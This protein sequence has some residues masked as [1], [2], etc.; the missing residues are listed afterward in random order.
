MFLLRLTNIMRQ[1]ILPRR[2]NEA[3]P[4]FLLL[5]V[6]R[7]MITN[8]ITNARHSKGIQPTVTIVRYRSHYFIWKYL[9]CPVRSLD[10]PYNT[11][12]A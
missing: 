10:I 2:L 1:T 6:A 3:T 8:T 11:K 5:C 4:K 12:S 7:G 9:E